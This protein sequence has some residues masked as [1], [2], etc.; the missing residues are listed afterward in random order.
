MCIKI[1]MAPA[2]RKEKIHDAMLFVRPLALIRHEHLTR[3]DVSHIKRNLCLRMG[4]ASLLASLLLAVFDA[5]LVVSMNVS[6][7]WKQIETYGIWSFIGQFGGMVGAVVVAVLQIWARFTMNEKLSYILTRIGSD[8]LFAIAAVEMILMVYTDAIM[9][10]T[11][12]VQALSAGIL[13]IA[14]LVLIQPAF[15]LD[16]IILDLWATAVMASVTVACHF[17]FGMG[18]LPYYILFCVGFPFACYLVVSVLFFAETNHFCQVKRNEM[19]YNSANYDEITKCKN[20]N[21][22]TH[23]VEE[24]IKRWGIRDTNLLVIMF[25]IDNFKQYNDQFSHLAGDVCLRSIADAIRKAFPSPDLDF[26][27]YGGEEFLLFFELRNPEDAGNIMEQARLAVRQIQ[28]QAPEGAPDKIVT[29][30]LGGSLVNSMEGKTFESVLEKVDHHLYSAKRN[31]KDVAC[32]DGRY[33][34]KHRK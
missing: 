5:I 26:F 2:S 3:R 23:F 21:A 33:V 20:R 28:L 15:W 25:D 6:S 11:K 31:G 4:I 1:T 7:G 10:Y 30:S 22:L 34:K 27:R 16:A 19:L 24:N 32:L 12:G 13:I 9:G 14:V 17:R 29:I 8:L 18:G